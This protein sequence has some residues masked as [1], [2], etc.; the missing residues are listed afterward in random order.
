[1][2]NSSHSSQ[3]KL[4]VLEERLSSYE[5]MMK[6]IDEAIQIMGQT[7]QNISKMLA[8]HEEKIEQC[9]RADGLISEL[10][11]E[12]KDENSRQFAV[13]SKRVDKV[14]EELKEI[15]KIRW[16]TVGCGVVLAVLVTAF[17][18]LASGWWKPFDVK[19]PS[20]ETSNHLI[21]M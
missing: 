5:L 16:M 13:V 1:M 8:V 19:L 4:A 11:H 21:S 7:N 2:L 14:E 15:G 20:H 17:S 3:T 18:T 6:R 12:V 10:I 9:N